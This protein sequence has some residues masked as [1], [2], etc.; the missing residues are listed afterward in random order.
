MLKIKGSRALKFSKIN[1]LLNLAGKLCNVKW[2]SPKFKRNR[3]AMN[4]VIPACL[5]AGR[6]KQESRFYFLEQLLDS[7]FR[8][9]DSARQGM[10]IMKTTS[11][12]I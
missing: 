3:L 6:R 11:M 12:R 9:N 7:H 1:F 10:V 5:P 2:Q 4:G 8:G